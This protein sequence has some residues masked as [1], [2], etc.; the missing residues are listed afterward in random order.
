MLC[1]GWHV[2]LIVFGQHLKREFPA[3]IEL[4]LG[5]HPFAFT[6]QIRQDAGVADRDFL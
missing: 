5:N 4:T 2:V 6:E 3:V 1:F